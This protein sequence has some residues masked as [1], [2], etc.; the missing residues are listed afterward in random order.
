M[1]FT[2]KHLF[3][4][5]LAAACS[6]GAHGTMLEWPSTPSRLQL[7]TPYGKL[8]ISPSE[9]VYESKLRLDSADLEPE[10][11]GM[12]NI[13]HAFKMPKAHAALVSINRGDNVCPV[14]YRWIVLRADGYKMSPEFGS[15]SELIKVSAQPGQLT[16]QTPSRESSDKIDI[17]DYDGKTV[18]QRS[19]RKPKKLVAI[20]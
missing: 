17:Y 15:C 5:L 6:F 2:S 1:S 14:M 7:S 3:A 18:K 19:S 12:L 9:Y 16:L 11:T 20:K 4:T 13:S 10:I 8:Y